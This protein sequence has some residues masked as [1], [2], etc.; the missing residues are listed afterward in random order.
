MFF[1]HICNIVKVQVVHVS[2]MGPLLS[3]EGFDFFA[4]CWINTN[5]LSKKIPTLFLAWGMS[6]MTDGDKSYFPNFK[7]IR[8]I[9]YSR[10]S[11]SAKLTNN[12]EFCSRDYSL[13]FTAIPAAPLSLSP[14]GALPARKAGVPSLRDAPFPNLSAEPFTNAPV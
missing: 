6:L 8:Q 11:S 13:T 2:G 5:I 7:N 10:L 1:H 9:K 14:K 12:P 3:Y 4:D